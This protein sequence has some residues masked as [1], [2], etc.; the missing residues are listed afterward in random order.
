MSGVII[1]CRR[2]LKV[3]SWKDEFERH[4][5]KEHKG[6]PLCW[7]CDREIKKGTPKK[8]TGII[9]RRHYHKKC[10]TVEGVSK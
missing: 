8:S 10:F 5:E 3:F 2:C 6:N 1:S 9:N 7:E 4:W